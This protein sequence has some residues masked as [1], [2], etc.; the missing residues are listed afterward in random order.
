MEQSQQY[1]L[2][3][4]VICP[5]TNTLTNQDDSHSIDN[6]SMQVLLFLIEG[7]GK[8]VT[9]DQIFEH[10]WKGKV[11][12]DDILSVTI[13]KIRKALRDNARSPIYIKTV[14][15]EGYVLIAESKKI[16]GGKAQDIAGRTN[17]RSGLS[18]IVK[19]GIAAVAL[20]ALTLFIILPRQDEP[21]KPINISSIA[22][23]PFDD[24]SSAKDKQH[25]TDGMSDAIINQLSQITSLK[26]ISRYSSFTYRGEYNATEI[27]DALKVDTLLDGSVQTMGEQVRINVRIFS[28]E[29]GQQLWSKTFDGD[30]NEIF[31]LQDNIG[32]TVQSII[33]PGFRSNSETERKI[34][35]QAYE[36]Y[37]LG[38]YHWRQRNPESLQQAVT[39]FKSSL[40]LEPDYA[41]AH[42]GLAITYEL[43]HT[44]GN[45]DEIK[46]IETALP[47]IDKAL[48]VNPD[49]AVALAAKGLVLT[50]KAVYQTRI[51]QHE[52]ELY[53]QAKRAFQSALELDDN[54]TTHQWYSGLLRR[55]GT[56][57]EVMRHLDKAIEL[58]PLSAPLKRSY[59]FV[60]K[61]MGKAD[62][63][64]RMYQKA[65]ELDRNYFSKPIESSRFNRYTRESILEMSAWHEQNQELISNCSSVE[66]C[67]HMVFMYLSIGAIDAANDI[68][69]T[70]GAT[71]FHFRTSLNAIAASEGG[72]DLEALRVVE[73]FTQWSSKGQR[74]LFDYA[75]AQFRAGKYEQAQTTLLQLFPVWSQEESIE[76]ADINADNYQALI[77]YAANIGKLQ[78]SNE[79]NVLLQKALE[80]LMQG[81]VFDQAEAEFALAEVY[82][83]L[84]EK[85][86]ALS[87]L[88][89]ALKLGWMETFSKEWW[90]LQNNHLLMP[91]RDEPEFKLLVEQHQKKREELREIISSE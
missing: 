1:Q 26:V 20:I 51:G 43:L 10:V 67:E 82:A 34:N 86:Q 39:Y 29:N 59:S 25:L 53:Q 75:I 55:I 80:F 84:G 18:F 4:W 91:L 5:R 21:S 13:S 33:Q 17:Q 50:E 66:Y 73:A 64:K 40:E 6:K 19:L 63:A 83:Q 23:L 56:E 2:G 87:R 89:N 45:W 28:T 7:E 74:L 36:W 52:P 22:V 3:P 61:S 38:Q 54:A 32:A 81:D 27:G 90:F 62:S 8:T 48:E 37:L 49:L 69:S 85:N 24:L 35:S 30:H 44:Y 46:S 11:V 57:S 12:A 9:K 72:D 31:E 65:L 70:M 47:H 42:V 71:H 41:E 58:N 78:R 77:L 15:G 76:Q 68:L 79:A 14:P 60:L 88:E 16:D